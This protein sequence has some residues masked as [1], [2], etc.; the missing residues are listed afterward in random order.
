MK[1]LIE[2]QVLVKRAFYDHLPL[3]EADK[4][5]IDHINRSFAHNTQ[6]RNELIKSYY[7][8]VVR[9]KTL[10]KTTQE[11]DIF[12]YIHIGQAKF[13]EELIF[14]N[15]FTINAK[16]AQGQTPLHYSVIYHQLEVFKKLIA[17]CANLNITDNEGFTVHDTVKT[18]HPEWDKIMSNIPKNLN[19]LKNID[20]NLEISEVDEDQDSCCAGFCKTVAEFFD[21]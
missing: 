15:P 11:K 9:H 20:G 7:S 6:Q 4:Y 5:E 12:H 10:N 2:E 17:L 1:D 13:V 21:L 3:D 14:K 8:K 16:N 18:Y 19:A